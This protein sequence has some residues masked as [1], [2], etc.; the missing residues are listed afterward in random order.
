M[1][2]PNAVDMILALM[3]ISTKKLDFAQSAE[4]KLLRKI[5]CFLQTQQSNYQNLRKQYHRVYTG[6]PQKEELS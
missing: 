6:S 3:D 5:R 2:S 4:K 1:V